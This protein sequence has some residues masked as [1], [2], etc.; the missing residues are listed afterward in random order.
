MIEGTPEQRRLMRMGATASVMVA[1]TLIAAK[2]YAWW[3]SD[4]V[5]LLGSLADSSLDFLASAVN[6]FAII[7]ALQP[8]DEEHRFGH[9]KAEA[10]AGLFQTSIIFG[11]SAFLVYW[12][13]LRIMNPVPIED[14]TLGIGVSVFA[15]LMTLGLVTFQKKVIA[16]TKSVAITADRLHYVG[17]LLLNGGVIAALILSTMAGIPA[18]DG[19]FGLA[20]ALYIGWNAYQIARTSIDMLMDKEFGPKEREKI[21]NL[22]MEN[23]DVKGLHDL[24]TRRSG[25]LSFIQMHIELDPDINLF[26]AHTI[27]DEVEATVGEEFPGA[28]IIIH[29]DPLGLEMMET[30]DE[31]G[32]ET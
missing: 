29:T 7:V 2:A 6:L 21:F 23:P 16:K 5:A 19:Y 9:G 10:I 3:V 30:H 31:L 12:S 24:K 1:L 18:A 14:G 20:I 11:S 25:L 13:T 26:E 27:A 22:V 8:A 32:K 15:I 4:S 17:D 28:E